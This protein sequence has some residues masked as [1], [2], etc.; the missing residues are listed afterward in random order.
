INAHLLEAKNLALDRAAQNADIVKRLF[1]EP[2]CIEP[3]EPFVEHF[4]ARQFGLQGA[5]VEIG[6]LAIILMKT[7][8][9]AGLRAPGE[10]ACEIFLREAC[11][12]GITLIAGCVRRLR[13]LRAA[14]QNEGQ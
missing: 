10:I 8:R 6:D 12:G 7:E 3:G 13:K 1:A 14:S 9:G 5:L 2:G 4:E 11:E